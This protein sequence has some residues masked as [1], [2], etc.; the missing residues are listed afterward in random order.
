M[1]LAMR[2]GDRTGVMNPLR[3][4]SI[5]SRTEPQS[6]VTTGSARAIASQTAA[7]PV[8]P[9]RSHPE[10]VEGLSQISDPA[11]SIMLN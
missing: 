9:L 1:T 3:P 11:A 10:D 5:I 8:R 6:V 2:S 4:S 7:G